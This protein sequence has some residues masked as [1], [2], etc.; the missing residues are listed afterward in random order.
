MRIGLFSRWFTYVFFYNSDLRR[1]VVI[2]GV[3]KCIF[4]RSEFDSLL[5]RSIAGHIDLLFDHLVSSLL[6][7]GSGNPEPASFT[8]G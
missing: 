6:S 2:A 1:V 4:H 8:S 5:S 7:D 3:R